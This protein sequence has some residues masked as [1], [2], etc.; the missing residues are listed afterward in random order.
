M[1]PSRPSSPAACPAPARWTVRRWTL[2][3]VG[4]VS[5]G[6]GALGAVVPG[7]PTTIFLIVAS[8]CF[9][10]SC[11]WLEQRLLRN[12]LFAPYM[13]YV[14]GREPM[15]RRARIAALVMMWGAIAISLAWLYAADR[16]PVWLALAIAGAG[17]AGTI[18]I[19]TDVMN[20]LRQRAADP[21]T[22]AAP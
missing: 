16:L 5:V 12:R 8:W 15:P 20:R 9:A 22:A 2:A 21:A 6:F 17:V 11:P 18:A 19:A 10:K 3:S 13:V 7:L 4:V 1:K 14:D